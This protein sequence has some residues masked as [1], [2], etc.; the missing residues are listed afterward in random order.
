[1]KE[2]LGLI[3]AYV[4][5]TLKIT[6]EG[7]IEKFE[8]PISRISHEWQNLGFDIQVP[9]GEIYSET[10]TDLEATLIGEGKK[11]YQITQVVKP[12]IYHQG[13]LI[14]KGIVICEGR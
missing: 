7:Q 5:L 14:Q 12:V 3:N 9:L 11:V 1:M 4:Q 6:Q 2:L 8:R 10:R 13:I